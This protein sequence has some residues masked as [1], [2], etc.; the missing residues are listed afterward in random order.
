MSK[1]NKLK[2]LIIAL[3]SVLQYSNFLRKGIVRHSSSTI[4]QIDN[5][6]NNSSYKKVISQD[7]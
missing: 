2:I 7:L 1:I 4:H 6:E 5:L 3:T